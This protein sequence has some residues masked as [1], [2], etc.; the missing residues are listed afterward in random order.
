[1][2]P[3]KFLPVFL[4]LSGIPVLVIGGGKVAFRKIKMF[5][6]ADAKITVIAPK[7]LPE[8][9]SIP[10]IDLIQREVSKSDIKSEFRFVILATDDE[11]LQNSLEEV[12]RKKRILCNRCDDPK[13]SDFVTGSVVSR[14]PI[15]SGMITGG[16]PALTKL[17]RKRFDATLGPEVTLLAKLL[18]EVRETVKKKFRSIL[19]REAFFRFW[20]SE[21][22]LKRIK[23][24]GIKKIRE[25]VLAC[26]S[27]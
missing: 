5:S 13:R 18:N 11:S 9:R 12:C 17:V 8:I 26:L 19:K 7:I 27:T 23:T 2:E 14:P 15:I 24:E 1:L 25:E 20:A 6:Q 10:N 3:L 16:S 21:K 4:N 22:T